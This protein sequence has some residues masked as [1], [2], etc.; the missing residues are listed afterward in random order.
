MLT[1]EEI[2]ATGINTIE[3]EYK[4]I[5][6]LKGRINDSFAGAVQLIYNSVGRVVITGI[7]KSANIGTKIVATLNS[8]GTP[9]IFMHAAD[10]I[11][12]D[13]GIIQDEDIV[14]IISKSGNTPE[15]KILVPLVKT[16][17]NKIIAIVGNLNSFL[18]KQADYNL[19]TTVDMEACPNNLAPTSSTTSQLVMGDALAVSLLK[20][21]NFSKEDFAKN[22]PGGILGKT[23]YLRVE[24]LSINNEKPVVDINDHIRKI[25]LEISSKRLGATAVVENDKLVG[26]I[27]DGDLRRMMEK[28]KDVD[29]L[30]ARDI[31]SINPKTIE[32]DQLAITAFKT[33]K[34]NNITQL[35]VVDGD[36]YFGVVHLHDILREGIL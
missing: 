30:I 31:M 11:H 3:Q 9:A 4:E 7:G 34:D 32:R 33:M 10:A 8:T 17:G 35:F 21:R 28:Y 27:T 22:H 13:L 18:A 16:L 29:P 14:I 36:S 24:D 15:I 5:F 12:G 23:L 1:K 26:A 6:K 19:D 25:I 20:N 2:I